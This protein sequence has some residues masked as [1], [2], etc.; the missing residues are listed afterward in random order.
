ME[1]YFFDLKMEEGDFDKNLV[2][3]GIAEFL[4]MDNFDLKGR[5]F[6][7]PFDLVKDGDE[8]GNDV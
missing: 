7:E 6:F 3:E 8:N 5:I 4:K 2:F 1:V